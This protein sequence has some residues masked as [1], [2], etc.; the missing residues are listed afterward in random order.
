MQRWFLSATV[1][2]LAFQLAGCKSDQPQQR[3]Q[4]ASAAQP[5]E[6][7]MEST[8]SPQAQPAPARERREE[9]APV[10]TQ[11]P[12]TEPH[13]PTFTTENN[14]TKAAGRGEPSLDQPER[15]AAWIL[16]DDRTGSFIDREGRPQMQWVI[17]A[18]V[19]RAP[20]FRVEVYEPLL[21][22]SLT[23]F[24]YMLKAISSEGGEVTY[25]VSAKNGA[26]QPGRR[27]SLLNPG[28]GFVVRNW[29]TGDE[30]R[31]I[32]P[33]PAGIYVLAATIGASGKET[34]A[35]TEFRVAEGTQQ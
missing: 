33:L 26:F 19:S 2:T 31:Q 24:N 17:D 29:A 22:E 1:F 10:R 7:Q 20:T 9:P 8:R 13:K 23:K 6:R 25:A 4:P 12:I 21:G 3:V 14:P 30:V 28:D 11:K 15:P 16:V 35:V 18:P 5:A 32:A 27:Y 34:A